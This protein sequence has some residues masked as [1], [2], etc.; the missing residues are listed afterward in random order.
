MM[1]VERW[2]IWWGQNTGGK[3]LVAPLEKASRW[4]GMIGNRL[5]RCK[6]AKSRWHSQMHTKDENRKKAGF[7]LPRNDLLLCGERKRNAYVVTSNSTSWME[8]WRARRW[9]NQKDVMWRVDNWRWGYTGGWNWNWIYRS[10]GS[11][12]WNQEQYDNWIKRPISQY[13]PT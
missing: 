7:C 2:W 12:G 6:R 11:T 1:I 4:I 5:R 10:V 13:T 3:P 9:G 8:D